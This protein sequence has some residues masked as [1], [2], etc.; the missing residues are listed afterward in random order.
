MP[1]G[2]TYAL[3]DR[4]TTTHCRP[5]LSNTYYATIGCNIRNA[6]EISEERL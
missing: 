3:N 5:E 2:D 1:F 6:G 4:E